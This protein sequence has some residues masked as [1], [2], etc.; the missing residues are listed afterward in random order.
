M[1]PPGARQTH[2]YTV[3]L[4][5]YIEGLLDVITKLY[6]SL[7]PLSKWTLNFFFLADYLRCAS[8]YSMVISVSLHNAIKT[9]E[10][11]LRNVSVQSRL[12][13]LGIS[14]WRKCHEFAPRVWYSTT[15]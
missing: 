14:G 5:V 7:S 12:G 9:R 6:T 3:I 8:Q 4:I 1:P 2:V 15:V 13:L 10:R 11:Q